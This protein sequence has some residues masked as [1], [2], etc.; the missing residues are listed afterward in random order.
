MP[1]TH[2]GGKSTSRAT[3]YTMSA[4]TTTLVAKKPSTRSNHSSR[5][6]AYRAPSA[7]S[8]STV[9]TAVS[10]AAAGPRKDSA[11]TDRAYSTDELT[12]SVSLATTTGPP[13]FNG[14]ALSQS[15][16][17]AVDMDSGAY[18][19]YKKFAADQDGSVYSGTSGDRYSHRSASEAGHQ[20]LRRESTSTYERDMDIIS[21]LER[22]RSMNLHD[23]MEAD[24]KQEQP[25]RARVR[26]ANVRSNS[27]RKLPDI[28]KI[29][30]PHSPKRQLSAVEP[31]TNFPNFVFTHQ[32]N[33][34]A[35]ANSNR[36]R[37]SDTGQYTAQATFGRSESEPHDSER[38]QSRTRTRSIDSRKSS[39]KSSH[40]PRQIAAGN[41]TEG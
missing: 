30:G 32:Y 36:N 34:F 14:S 19:D 31:S 17:I 13:Y 10:A 9:T 21:L 23:F 2:K 33:E 15:S 12:K 24:R 1:L 28:T 39:T 6:A 25:P 4:P 7:S 27:G 16:G 26:S 8:P 20:S 35:E 29:A 37:D 41:Y 38:R 40:D 22:E 18:T 11:R 3:S 5:S